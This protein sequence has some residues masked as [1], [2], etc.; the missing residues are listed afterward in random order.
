MLRHA[1][2]TTIKAQKLI[3]TTTTTTAVAVASITFSLS[4]F[5]LALLPSGWLAVIGESM[6]QLQL[7]GTVQLWVGSADREVEKRFRQT[8]FVHAAEDSVGAIHVGA[9]VV[10]PELLDIQSW[11]N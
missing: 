6:S 1:A 8:S 5:F 11:E 9:A 10:R 4:L 7:N 2:S 3:S